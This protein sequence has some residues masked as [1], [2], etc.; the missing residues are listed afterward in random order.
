MVQSQIAELAKSTGFKGTPSHRIAEPGAVESLAPIDNSNRSGRG[1]IRTSVD[2][3]V[4]G[5]Y[6]AKG[7]KLF[8]VQQR[9][10]VFVSYSQD[11]QLETMKT[12]RDRIT[13]DFQAKYGR[14]FNVTSVYVQ[15]LPLAPDPASAQAQTVYG[16]SRL[17]KEMTRESRARYEIETQR[18]Q[19]KTNIG[20]IRGRYGARR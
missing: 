16:G 2:C 11:S 4:S 15:P 6:V 14:T 7:G 12:V 13:S 18:L 5:Q 19:A 10:T 8:E 1:N 20:S 3:Y 17:F 9:Y